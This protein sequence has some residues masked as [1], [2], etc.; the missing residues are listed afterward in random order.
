MSSL[1]WKKI[2]N[3]DVKQ[4]LDSFGFPPTLRTMH[5]R[6]YSLGVYSNTKSTYT[7]LSYITARAREQGILPIN[8]FADDTRNVIGNFPD[9]SEYDE[10]E[11]YIDSLIHALKHITPY[12]RNRVSRWRNQPHHVEVWTEKKAMIRTFESILGYREVLIVPFGGYTS[13][14]YHNDNCYRLKEF[15]DAGKEIHILYYGDMDPSGENIQQDIENKLGQYGVYDVDF[16]RIAITEEQITSYHLPTD[17]DSRTLAKLKNDTRSNGF[18]S[19][20]NGELF[21]VEVDSLPAIVPQ[22]FKNIVL[23]PVDQ[24]FDNNIYEELST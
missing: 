24:Y 21:Q 22:E 23:G 15:Q 12:C 1:D 3:E 9:D 4:A 6:L 17:P 13:I 7:Q 8:C 16:R 14:T 11:E 2:V 20:H 18:M 10:P 5:Y 19:E